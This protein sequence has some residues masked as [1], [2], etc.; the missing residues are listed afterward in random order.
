MQIEIINSEMPLFS[1]QIDRDKCED[2]S[3][4]DHRL[5]YNGINNQ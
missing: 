4:Q 2:H 5:G 3:S 1:H